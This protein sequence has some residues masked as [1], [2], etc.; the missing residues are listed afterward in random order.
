MEQ[1]VLFKD[2]EGLKSARN[3]IMLTFLTSSMDKDGLFYL[4]AELGIRIGRHYR[5][6]KIY[7]LKYE[8][9]EDG[10][11]GYEMRISRLPVRVLK[12]VCMRL[13]IDKGT[14]NRIADIDV[15]LCHAGKLI[16]ISRKPRPI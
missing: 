5:D 7:L 16:K 13:E 10:G 3:H 12:G 14:G 9:Q 6:T 15:F 8:E 4:A 1:D 2:E 11:P